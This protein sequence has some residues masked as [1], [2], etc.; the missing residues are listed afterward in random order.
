MVRYSRKGKHLEILIPERKKKQ[1]WNERDISRLLLLDIS[2]LHLQ[3]NRQ[4][5]YKLC[6]FISKYLYLIQ[7]LYLY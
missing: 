4:S 7:L 1:E 5:K 2:T 3:K 6:D